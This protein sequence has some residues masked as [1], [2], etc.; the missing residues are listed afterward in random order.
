MASVLTLKRAVSPRWTLISVANPWM[1][2]SPAPVISHSDAGLPGRDSLHTTAFAGDVHASSRKRAPAKPGNPRT[3]SPR[4]AAT[5][6]RNTNGV[7]PSP[8][9]NCSAWPAASICRRAVSPAS[10]ARHRPDGGIVDAT[11][12]A[13]S[14]NGSAAALKAYFTC[15]ARRRH[16]NDLLALGVGPTRVRYRPRTRA[17]AGCAR[18][19]P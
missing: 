13:C 5:T 4:T 8:T 2:E 19:W 14:S 10:P 6:R 11:T 17:R 12:P 3:A 1:L 15:T 9:P 16:A 18:P 7:V